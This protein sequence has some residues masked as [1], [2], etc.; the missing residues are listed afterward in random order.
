VE[1]VS[2][3]CGVRAVFFKITLVSARY[4]SINQSCWCIAQRRNRLGLRARPCGGGCVFQDPRALPLATVPSLR[5]KPP[6]AFYFAPLDCGLEW[7]PADCQSALGPPPR[8]T[9]GCQRDLYLQCSSSRK[10]RERR[11]APAR[12][13]RCEGALGRTSKASPGAARPPALGRPQ[14]AAVGT[15]PRNRAR[16]DVTAAYFA[17][18]SGGRTRSRVSPG[19]ARGVFSAIRWFL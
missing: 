16:G 6:K 5:H 11:W 4:H 10:E 18:R 7:L 2:G 9:R 1:G 15:L 8:P 3:G 12:D 14:A 19:A 17:W 13:V